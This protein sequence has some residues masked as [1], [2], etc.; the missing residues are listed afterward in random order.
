MPYDVNGWSTQHG[1]QNT[2]KPPRHADGVRQNMLQNPQKPPSHA[3]GLR[4]N[5][6]D[7]SVEAASDGSSWRY[8]RA[9]LCGYRYVFRPRM[10]GYWV[11]VLLMLG[12]LM[13]VHGA[14]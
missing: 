1:P 4:Q 9:L 2:Q 5:A 13:L 12:A 6:T 7:Q 10:W 3:D 8:T 11:A 14:R